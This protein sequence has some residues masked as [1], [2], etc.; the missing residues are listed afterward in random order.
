MAANKKEKE[1]VKLTYACPVG[2]IDMAI[3]NRKIRTLVD[4]GAE[5]NIIPE[6]LASQ[7]GMVTT[8][9]FMRLQGIGGHSNPIVGI[10]EN[11]EISL[12]PGYNKMAHFFIVKGSVHIVLGRPFLADH[13]VR[14]DLSS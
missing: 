11:T 8:E 1:E 9:V 5:M 6:E 4:T 14:L 10:A 12:L 3:D 13:G 2:M 7:L